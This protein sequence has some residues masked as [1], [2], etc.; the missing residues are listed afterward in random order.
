M[1]YV[2]ER[3]FVGQ[4]RSPCGHITGCGCSRGASCCL[5]CPLAE[6]VFEDVRAQA[7][8]KRVYE[9]RAMLGMRQ[10]GV[11]LRD[12]AERYGLAKRTV[13]RRIQEVR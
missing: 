1:A 7:I 13:L 9:G 11:R 12:I 10:A 8:S 2:G 3:A 6:C 4:R 5:E